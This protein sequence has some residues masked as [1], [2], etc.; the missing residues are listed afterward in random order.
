MNPIMVLDMDWSKY[1]LIL[2]YLKRHQGIIRIEETA[3]DLNIPAYEVNE[4]TKTL[5]KERPCTV[6]VLKDGRLEYHFDTSDRYDPI[7][8]RIRI[9]KDKIIGGM[10]FRDF[11]LIVDK[12]GYRLLLVTSILL[13]GVIFG[14]NA[15]FDPEVGKEYPS[16]FYHIL[17]TLGVA[18]FSIFLFI[19]L[20]ACLI[21]ATFLI[22]VC[23]MTILLILW[24]IGVLISDILFAFGP[25][26]LP[27]TINKYTQS[28]KGYL[29]RLEGPFS[30]IYKRWIDINLPTR[31]DLLNLFASRK[32]VITWEEAIAVSGWKR[33]ELQDHLT[34]MLVHGNGD[35]EVTDQGIIRYL[36]PMRKSKGK[37][38]IYIWERFK[39]CPEK[40]MD[41][42][43]RVQNYM[44]FTFSVSSPISLF[45]PISNF[46]LSFEDIFRAM[47][48]D[49]LFRFGYP[50]EMLS[51][52][53]VITLSYIVF[54]LFAPLM[55]SFT[56][57]LRNARLMKIYVK[58]Q[59]LKEIFKRFEIGGDF[60]KSLEQSLPWP[61]EEDS[62][63]HLINTVVS[64]VIL[65]LGGNVDATNPDR[66]LFEQVKVACEEM[67]FTSTK[68]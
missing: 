61:K 4:I 41:I 68:E 2:E 13:I 51:L 24:K 20:M 8:I 66:I 9:I 14:I 65:D 58:A 5:I 12:H 43:Q 31:D 6:R 59:I 37:R 26:Y 18:L 7:W 15:Y 30:E 60:L 63:W 17:I 53:G 28:E 56:T 3:L 27:F 36:I 33:Q 11:L 34:L 38:P 25:P 32:G 35:I 40:K 22:S 10:T 49:A 16:L 1:R 47:D 55:F 21:P 50:S 54:S 19:L 64:E 48:A 46:F 52:F 45:L 57:R 62:K 67:G 42:N 29:K 23:I 44:K 39:P